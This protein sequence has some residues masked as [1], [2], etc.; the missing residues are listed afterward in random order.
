MTRTLKVLATAFTA[1]VFLSAYAGN[2]HA[3]SYKV[4]D[5]RG[6]T[7]TAT[8]GDKTEVTRGVACLQSDG[9]WRIANVQKSRRVQPQRLTQPRHAAIQNQAR[10]TVRLQAP[11][12]VQST[13]RDQF[14]GST[15]KV[16]RSLDYRR[17]GRQLDSRKSR[18]KDDTWSALGEIADGIFPKTT[19]RSRRSTHCSSK[20]YFTSGQ[21]GRTLY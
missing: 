1:M 11:D 20:A 6:F 9:A 13:C 19:T 10:Q 16:R 2:S 3:G 15:T 21:P 12:R 18:N 5:C 8:I 7:A 17:I 4:G 14:Y